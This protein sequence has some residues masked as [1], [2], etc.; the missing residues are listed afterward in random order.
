MSFT[1]VVAQIATNSLQ[2]LQCIDD[3][4]LLA[5]VGGQGEELRCGLHEILSAHSRNKPKRRRLGLE[6]YEIT[7]RDTVFDEMT[8]FEEIYNN[9]NII[10]SFF[11]Q[12]NHALHIIIWVGTLYLM[13]FCRIMI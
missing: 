2:V 7:T 1:R 8:I 5:E 4:K 11:P 10:F 6:Y 9:E 3:P 13:R 12:R